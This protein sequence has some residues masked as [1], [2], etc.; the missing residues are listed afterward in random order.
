MAQSLCFLMVCCYP[1]IH[2]E[3]KRKAENETRKRKKKGDIKREA[4]SSFFSLLSLSSVQLTLFLSSITE[5]NSV[6]A[7]GR[8]EIRSMQRVVTVFF[9]KHRGV[10]LYNYR[11][12]CTLTNQR[13]TQVYLK[14][15]VPEK[16]AIIVINLG[17]SLNWR[18]RKV[19]HEL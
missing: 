15:W 10:L 7:G 11:H 17:F 9:F 4:D 6:H 1:S 16:T 5:L 18:M 3:L 19:S 12:A 14:S 13:N 8:R 2:S